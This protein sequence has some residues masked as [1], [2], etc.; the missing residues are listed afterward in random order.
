VYDYHVHS[1]YSDG[2]F[3]G[4]MVSAAADAGLDGVGIADHCNVWPTDAARAYRTRMGFNLDL[5]Y[6]RRREAI[7]R[8]RET[9]DIDV[10]DAAEM[11]YEP[12]FEESIRSFLDEAEFDYALG[13]VH[14][15]DETNVHYEDHFT[16]KSERER[17]RLVGVYFDK[18]VA[19]I[20]S[21]LFEIAAHPD[22]IER[23][24]AL[25][26][27]A[28]RDQYER[29]AEAFG[30]SRTIPEINAGRVRDEYGEFHPEPTFL[31][32]LLDHGVELTV[33]SDSHRPDALDPRRAEIEAELAARGV[34]PVR[35]GAVA[36]APTE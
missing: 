36:E 30:E 32:V 7:E 35:V 14:E 28:T 26:G 31:D 9:T 20:E 25:R 34:E 22:L 1:T 29:V 16:E 5:T 27:F 2:R 8:V 11:D 33:G 12:A 21:E 6:E 15:L 23:N 13:S 3:L 4:R 18:L 10:Y 19:L 24:P 17:E